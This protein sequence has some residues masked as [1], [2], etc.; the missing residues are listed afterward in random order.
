MRN[1]ANSLYIDLGTA[2]TLIYQRQKG[3]L[4]REPSV[5]AFRERAFSSEEIATGARAKTM[6]GKNP[7]NV[8][9]LKPLSQGVIASQ[10]RAGEMMR[11]FFNKIQITKS[12]RKPHMVISL[13][14]QV[15]E[16]EAQAVVDLGKELGASRVT[17]IDEPVAAALGAGL[18]VLE[19]TSSMMI[20]IGGGTSE[21]ALLS[22]GGIIHSQAVRV[23][24]D[25]IDSAIIQQLAMQQ[26]FAI[27]EQTAE[28]LKIHV[29][30]ALAS[31]HLVI[32]AGGLNTVSGLP[33]R[34]KI[35]SAH[36]YAAVDGVV[37][38]IIAAVRV[39]LEQSPP[40]VAADL[41]ECGIVLAGGG[42]LLRGLSRRFEMETGVK[43]RLAAD[44]LV[45]VAAGGARA[46][47]DFRLLDSLARSR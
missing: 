41:A 8:S 47:E 22:S 6:L 43:T 24:G 44:P 1:T 23:G 19:H 33:E 4:L 37:K 38:Q 20:D 9:V 27:G 21:I 39:A 29:A 28:Y 32:E 3:L 14:C 31:D 45:S 36:V 16:F 42:A 26:H 30:S 13:P 10:S 35:S 25:A 11:A 2:N 46:V 17:L 18:P 15:T 12:W 40:E 34:R 7:G 5:I